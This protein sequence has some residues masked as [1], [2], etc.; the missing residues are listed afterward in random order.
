MCLHWLPRP[1][2]AVATP[3][4]A[5]YLMT[6]SSAAIGHTSANIRLVKAHSPMILKDPSQSHV[7]ALKHVFIC[8]PTAPPLQKLAGALQTAAVKQ[9]ISEN[10]LKCLTQC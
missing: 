5:S 2:K 10:I 9:I 1:G 7:S 8:F 4:I 3:E 6:A